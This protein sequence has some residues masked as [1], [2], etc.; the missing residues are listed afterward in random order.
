MAHRTPNNRKATFAGDIDGLKRHATDEEQSSVK[1]APLNS[2]KTSDAALLQ[3]WN[4][5]SAF[6]VISEMPSGKEEVA[7]SMRAF[8]SYPS[9][10]DGEKVLGQFNIAALNTKGRKEKYDKTVGQDNCSVTCFRQSGSEDE[11]WNCFCCLDGHGEDG[12]W[13]SYRACRTIPFFLTGDFCGDLLQKNQ[14]EEAFDACFHACEEDL[15]SAARMQRVHIQACGSTAVVF[16]QKEGASDAWVA[17]TGDSRAMVFNNAGEVLHESQDHKPSVPDERQRIEEMGCEVITTTYDDGEIEERVNI[18][19]QEYPGISFTRSLG[20]LIV[21]DHG[22]HAVPQVERWDLPDEGWMF[23]ASD[24]VYEFMESTIVA[25]QLAAAMA[26]GQT[27]RQAL[28]GL[29]KTA[30][31]RWEEIEGIYCD[32]ISALLIPVNRSKLN[33][34]LALGPCT[35]TAAT[36]AQGDWSTALDEATRKE[37]DGN[38]FSGACQGKCTIL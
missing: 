31:G 18:K 10:N 38:C 23:C 16:L 34:S 1:L 22:V 27:G 35:G 30:R 33:M 37:D 26:E 17:W 7:L 12:Q 29:L 25:K 32:D 6:H 36:N 3:K 24:G 15:E 11:F 21:K 4:D 20:D 14:V 5:G 19:G 28:H 8:R 13:V 9:R 2:L